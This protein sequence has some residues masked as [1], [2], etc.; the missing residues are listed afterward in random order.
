MCVLQRMLVKDLF[1][2]RDVTWNWSKLNG[3]LFQIT[4]FN[5]FFSQNV[6]FVKGRVWNS[7]MVSQSRIF[8][9]YV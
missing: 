3:D 6:S 9:A 1:F 8:R 2:S 4:S 7:D 5:R